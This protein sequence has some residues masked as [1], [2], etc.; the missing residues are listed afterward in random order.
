MV[1]APEFVFFLAQR[2][3]AQ[4]SQAPAQWRKNLFKKGLSACKRLFV[5]SRNVTKS[6]FFFIH[7]STNHVV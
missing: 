1:V 7:L 6:S 4:H 5:K 2:S 3:Q